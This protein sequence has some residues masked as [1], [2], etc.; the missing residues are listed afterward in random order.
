MRDLALV[1]FM[2]VMLPLALRRPIYGVLLWTWLSLM[3]PH[4][5]TWGFAFDLPFAMLTALATIIGLAITRDQKQSPFSGPMWWLMLF[6]LWIS[7][8]FPFSMYPGDSYPMWAKVLK[9]QLMTF[10]AVALLTERKHVV[11]FMAVIVASLGYYG[12]KGGFFT[13]RGGGVDMV[14]GPPGTFIEGNNE[15]A[16][17]LIMIVP[18]MWYVFEV[19]ANKWIRLA[20]VGGMFLSAMAALGSQSR[21]ALL[22]FAAM[23]ATFWW[24]SK[25]K[26][27]LGLALL[28]TVPFMIAFMPESWERRMATI[29]TYETDG[30]AMGRINAWWNAWNLAMDHPLF[31][32]GFEIYTDEVFARYAPNPNDIHAAHSI[33]FQVLGEHGWI[34][35]VI[36]IGMWV[37][38]WR[39]AVW[40]R[41]HTTPDG[42]DRWAFHLAAMAQVSLAGFAVGGAFLS[43]AYFDLPYFLMAAL[44]A[45]RVVVT[46]QRAQ[47]RDKKEQVAAKD[48]EQALADAPH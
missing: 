5:L 14:W 26:L 25:R 10:V 7:L 16:L 39:T 47:A 48:V 21:G 27:A 4:R 9:I 45:T 2:A 30:S 15:V 17:A 1:V 33:Y 31:G 40:L 28:A 11:W 8:G 12:S 34:A 23:V 42:P 29:A 46:R 37:S 18:L 6:I 24:Y 36:F 41:R 44:V 3:N 35:F 38:T 19:I 22:G 32:G 43:L 13:L 20:L